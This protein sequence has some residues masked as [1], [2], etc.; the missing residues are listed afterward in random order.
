MRYRVLGPMRVWDGDRWAAVSAA[1]QRLLLAVLLVEPGAISTE[2]LVEEIWGAHPPRGAYGTLHGYVFRLRRVLGGGPGGPLV[3]RDGGYELIVAE[4]DV[5]THVF[6]D[7]VAT[8]RRELAFGRVELAA[9]RLC[10][11]L[12]LWRGPALVDVA[13]TS[14]VAVEAARLEQARLEASELRVHAWLRLGRH[15]DV[16]DAARRLTEQHPLRESLWEH[17]M[18]ALAALGRR[19]EALETYRRAREAIVSALGLEP[20]PGLRAIQRA[21]LNG[22]W[23]APPI[24]SGA[25]RQ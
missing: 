18:S 5:D 9:S 10:Q 21:V 19:H 16:V 24:V 3:R 12:S 20:G 23:E 22:R 14:A 11:A 6:V 1:Q 2:R 25:A 7:L 8:A 13:A 17:L 4:D 15:A